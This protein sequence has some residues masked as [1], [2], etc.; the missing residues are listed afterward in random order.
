MTLKWIKQI[1]VNDM[2][3]NTNTYASERRQITWRM[4][5]TKVYC[6]NQMW[7]LPQ[8]LSSEVARNNLS[9]KKGVI[10][11]K[12]NSLNCSTL[13]P[14]VSEVYLRVILSF[15]RRTF[16]TTNSAVATIYD[17]TNNDQIKRHMQNKMIY[18]P[19]L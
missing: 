5:E 10:G 15:D 12:L 16:F 18:L 2:L 13:W 14:R 9:H 7:C 11:F 8:I 19:L 4:C 1:T 17:I 6:G 3:A